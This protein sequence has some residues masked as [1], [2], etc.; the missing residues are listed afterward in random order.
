MRFLLLAALVAAGSAVASDDP[1]LKGDELKA[2]IARKC[3]DGCVTWSRVDAAAFEEELKELVA[4]VR[5]EAYA[6]GVQAQRAAC[7]S[8]L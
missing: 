3:G 5:K 2:D 8:L 1:F 4:K 7:R 6:A